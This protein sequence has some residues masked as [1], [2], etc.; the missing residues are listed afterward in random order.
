MKVIFLS[1]GRGIRMLP[2]TKDIPKPLLN[3]GNDLTIIGSQLKSIVECGGIEEIIFVVGCMAEKI[4]VELRSFDDIPIKFI[5]NPFYMTSNN[6]ISLWFASSEMSTDFV[7]INGDDVFKSI[8]LRQ[9][10]DEPLEKNI[11]M[12]IDRKKSYSEEDMKVIIHNERIVRVS[13]NIPINEANGESIGMIKFVGG[14]C[15]VIRNTLARMVRKDESK[16]VFYLEALQ[17]VI[18][19]GL[20]VNYNECSEDE[21]AEIDFHPDLKLIR[22]NSFKFVT[23]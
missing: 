11:V 6:L 23:K 21:W 14:G 7:V 9:L 8:V 13:K 15:N 4:E 1:A 5:Y 16:Q 22:K 18:D 19:S 2:L 10:L 3:I 12:V 17:Q 20:P